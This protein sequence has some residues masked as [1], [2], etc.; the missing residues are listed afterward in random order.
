MLGWLF[1][2]VLPNDYKFSKTFDYYN[3]TMMN[4]NWGTN[5]TDSSLN[6]TVKDIYNNNALQLV[7][8]YND[9]VYNANRVTEPNCDMRIN[10][11]FKTFWEYFN[12][13]RWNKIQILVLGLYLIPVL[14]LLLALK[15]LHILYKKFMSVYRRFW[16]EEEVKD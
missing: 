3:F 1:D 5:T 14:N 11:R 13:Y 8:K 4:F 7:L 12:Y 10:R 2:Y 6:I 9:L 15:L 16:P